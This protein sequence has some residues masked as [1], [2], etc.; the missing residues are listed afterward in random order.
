MLTLKLI[1]EE[2]ERVI[3]GLEKKHFEGAREA[4]EKV[5]NIDRQRREAQ[6][7]L[8]NNKQ[9]ANQLSKQIGML[10]KDGKKDEAEAVKTKV[11]ELKDAAKAL[12]EKQDNAEKDL[13]TLLC[14]IPN[15]PYDEVPQGAHAEDNWVVKSNLKECVIGEDT[16]GNWTCNPENKDAKVPHWE[17]A[18]KYNLIDFDLGVKIT[19]AGFPVYIGKGAQLQRALINFFLAEASKAGYTEIMPPTVVNAASGYGTGQLPDKE[20]QMYHCEVDD[21]YLIPTAEVPVTNIYR[22]VILDEKDLPIKNCAYTQCFRREAGSYGKDVRGLNRLHEFSKI[23]IVRIDTPEHSAESHKEMLDHVEGLL[24][25]L[26]LPYRILRLCGGDQS[27]TSAI[28]YDFEVYSEAQQRWLEVSSVSNFDTYQANRL[29]CR[30]RK[31]GDKKIELCHTLNGSA[32]ALPRIVASILED[33]QTPEGIRVPK[34]LVPYMGC[35]IIK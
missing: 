26:E 35:D 31:S 4:I 8:D 34:A 24:K 30:Y 32:L 13:T 16:V 5:Q 19:G 1:N 20:G 14:Q 23:E 2:T 29:H 11:A 33:Y 9:E 6:Q 27:F 17:L 28:C 10:M 3:A 25:K 7:A 21:L 12:Q 22:D 18:K 15:I